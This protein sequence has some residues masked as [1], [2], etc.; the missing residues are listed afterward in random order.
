MYNRE[1]LNNWSFIL[2][3]IIKLN[4]YN[5]SRNYFIIS[6]MEIVPLKSLGPKKQLLCCYI[7]TNDPRSQIW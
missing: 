4:S 6:F 5:F 7:S 3:L 2:F 1:L